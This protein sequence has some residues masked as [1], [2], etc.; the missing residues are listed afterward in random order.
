MLD[1]LAAAAVIAMLSFAA[2][3][4]GLWVTLHLPKRTAGL[5]AVAVAFVSAVFTLTVRGRLCMTSLLPFSAVVVLGDWLP[6]GAGYLAGVLAG[7]ASLAPWRKILIAAPMTLLAWCSIVQCF[8]TGVQL[9]EHPWSQF[10]F[11]IQSNNVSCS[12]TAGAELL[13]TAG[14]SADE[15]EMIDVCLTQSAGTTTLGLYRGLTLKAAA[16]GLKVRPF[17]GTAAQAREL[18]GPMLAFVYTSDPVE[19]A[20]PLLSVLP[21]PGDHSIIVYGFTPRGEA[22][23]GDPAL[24]RLPWTRARFDECFSGEALQLVPIHESEPPAH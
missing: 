2:Y 23:V 14:I 19:R 17:Y 9:D 11:P 22:D 8:F 3:A 10:G 16:A 15:R 12:P 24:G 6:I 21:S 7:D 1:L 4:A 18:R 20:E 13:R 5:I